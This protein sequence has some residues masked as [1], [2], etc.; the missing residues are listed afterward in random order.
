MEKETSAVCLKPQRTATGVVKD[1]AFW[2]VSLVTTPIELLDLQDISV[3][4]IRPISAM[5]WLLLAREYSYARTAV[6]SEKARP[7]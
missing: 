3:G 2:P 6:C 5:H 1:L 4:P 7:H